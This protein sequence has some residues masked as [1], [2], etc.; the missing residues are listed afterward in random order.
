MATLTPP[1]PFT[2]DPAY[3]TWFSDSGTFSPASSGFSN[4]TF[5]LSLCAKVNP[6]FNLKP[7]VTVT[8]MGLISDP[9]T[10]TPTADSAKWEEWEGFGITCPSDHCFPLVD[11]KS[12]PTI[13]SCGNIIRVRC[14]CPC[15]NC[16]AYCI[17]SSFQ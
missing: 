8:W 16:G 1:P 13:D 12:N 10:I 11:S 5:N 7:T 14:D 4:I 15:N 9:V 6:K 2:L 3:Y 17:L